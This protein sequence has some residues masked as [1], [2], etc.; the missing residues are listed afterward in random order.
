MKWDTSCVTSSAHRQTPHLHR[1]VAALSILVGG[2]SLYFSVPATGATPTSSQTSPLSLS[3]VSSGEGWALTTTKCGSKEC[4]RLERSGNEGASWS[5]LVL[6]APLQAWLQAESSISDVSSGQ[7]DVYFANNVDGWIYGATAIPVSGRPPDAELWATHNG[8]QTWSRIATAPL[9]LRFDVLTVSASSGWVY[10]IGW[11]SD[12]TFNL[13]RAPVGSNTWQH[14]ATPTLDA[15]AGGTTMEGA[16]IFRGDAGWLMVGND[17]GATGLA[18]MTPSGTWVKWDGPCGPVGDSDAVPVAL[19][20]TELV[21]GCTIGGYGGD[22]APGT[23][24][25]LKMNTE[26]L[27]SSHDGGTSF[28][29]L[30]EVGSGFKTQWLGGASS[31]SASSPLFVERQVQSGKSLIERLEVSRNEGQSW[32]SVYAVRSNVVD[33]LFGPVSFADLGLGS[34][35]VL[36]GLDK[37]SLLISTD[38]GLQ[39][40][41]SDF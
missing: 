18:R 5:D 1:I 33:S 13:W 27:F 2:V 4:V 15:A 25:K 40:V 37:S 19:S 10:A 39:W 26:W 7:P 24:R 16:L 35:I 8:G 23:P 3:F 22:V 9:A 34:V 30:R 12:D 20:S 36:N 31:A 21:D 6:P 11:R 28:S 41:R 14:V 17:R 32:T 29:P 38:G